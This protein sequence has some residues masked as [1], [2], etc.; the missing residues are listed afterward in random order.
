MGDLK[1]L[2]EF[3]QELS[4]NKSIELIDDVLARVEN[5]SFSLAIVGEFK[6]G[7]STFINALLGKDILPSDILPCSATLNRVR[8]GITPSV[9]VIYKNGREDEVGIDKLKDYV[10]KLTPEA[11]E[12]AANIKEAIV[13]YP[14][15]YC[16]NNVDIIDTPGL[17]DDTNMTEVTLSVLPE[18]DAAIMVIMA[19]SPFSEYEKNFLEQKLLTND[20]GRVIF[21]VTGIDRYNNPS[22][23]DR[24]IQFIQDRIT[25]M[26]LQRIEEQYGKNSPEYEVYQKKIGTPKVFGLSAYQAL[27]AKEKGNVEL[28]KESRFGEFEAA[29]EKFLTEERGATFLQVP[30]N[31]AIASATEI[32]KTLEIKENALAMKHE[33][34]EAAHNK[35][36]AEIEALRLRNAEEMEKIDRSVMEVK[37]AVQPLIVGLIKQLRQSAITTIDAEVIQPAELKNQQALTERLGKKVATAVEKTAQLQSEKIQHEIEKGLLKEVNRLQDFAQEI[38]AGLQRIEMQ[39]TSVDASTRLTTN[40]G[41]QSI[42]A[43]LAVFTGFGGIWSGYRQAG[44]KG[45]AVGA[46]GSFGTFFAA[47]LIAGIIGLPVTFP[48]L[49]IVGVVSIFTGGGLAKAVFAKERVE[50]FKTNYKEAVIK[51]INQ[52]MQ[53]NPLAQKINPQIDEIF[54]ALKEKIRE[55]VGSVLD[56]TQNTLAEVSAKREREEV[57]TE[58]EKV[59]LQ[60]MRTQTERI[61]GSAQG[62][63]RQLIQQINMMES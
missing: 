19:Q 59:E 11:E 10:T 3:S 31:R 8:Y 12:T 25:K 43:A 2:R 23:A 16:Q 36:M 57:M 27:Q 45:G 7:K 24:A 40:A 41:G 30:L 44:I 6:R 51:E 32:I 29:I 52:R 4:L 14:V 1:K 49:V 13:S 18:V 60:S 46:A 28:L 15:H 17:N 50:N 5:K 39:F 56:D 9:K 34:F 21:V 54:G 48:V 33:E 63:S 61:L 55:E 35:S 37:R 26:V 38:T 47:G 53:D 58:H 42:A 20:L 62:L 22:D